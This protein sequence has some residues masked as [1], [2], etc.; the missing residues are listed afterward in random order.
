M[1]GAYRAKLVFALEGPGGNTAG[2]VYAG[3]H[4]AALKAIERG[5]RAAADAAM[6]D[7][8]PRSLYEECYFWLA[9]FSYRQIWGTPA[10]QLAALEQAIAYETSASYLPE[11]LFAKA[12]QHKFVL[13]VKTNRY[14]DALETWKAL[15]EQKLSDQARDG[16]RKMAEEIEQLQTDGR[17]F[18]V[19][20]S[21][22]ADGVWTLRLLKSRFRL[23]VASGSITALVLHC[24]RQRLQLEVD[25]ALEY[26]TSAASGQCY[27]Q[28]AG[29]PGTQFS[30]IQS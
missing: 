12:L 27:L 10:E 4:R 7:L 3:R 5:D 22:D 29:D 8:K 15:R 24:D 18:A 1:E 26:V 23:A 30:L 16:Y 2:K 17:S 28:V 14:A 21:I 19:A 6:A 25:P 20:D 13:E 9:R 11:K